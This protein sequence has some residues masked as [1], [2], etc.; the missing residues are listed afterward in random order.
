MVDFKK[1]LVGR[2]QA[3]QAVTPMPASCPTVAIMDVAENMRAKIYCI[4]CKL[5]KVLHFVM[6]FPYALAL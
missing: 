6:T 5:G 3:C 1:P 4:I 2:F